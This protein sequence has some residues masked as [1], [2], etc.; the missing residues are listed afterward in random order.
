MGFFFSFLTWVGKEKV[1]NNK[2]E[3]SLSGNILNLF[4][5]TTQNTTQW[6][7]C[8]SFFSFYTGPINT[9]SAQG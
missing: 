1:L 9:R 3:T 5:D 8:D 7:K 2:Q 6:T 4:K